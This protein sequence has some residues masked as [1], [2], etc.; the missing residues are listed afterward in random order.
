[1]TLLGGRTRRTLSA[2]ALMAATA[3]PFG[4]W[5]LSPAFAQ[6]T[7]YGPI[8][9]WDAA[10]KEI[11][12]AARYSPDGTHHALLIALRELHDPALKPF[13]QSLVQGEHWSIQIDGILGLAELDPNKQVDPFLLSQLK[14]ENDRS[15]AIAAAIGLDLVGPDQATAMLAWDDL[16]ARDRVVLAAELVHRGGKPA[17]DGITKLL[18]HRNDE[19]AGLAAFV[20]A[21][22]NNDPTPVET[23]RNRL[24]TLSAKDRIAVFAALANAIGRFKLT[25]ATSFLAETLKDPA[26]PI[27]ARTIGLAALLPLDP[28]AG[29]AAWKA[30]VES[31]SAQSSRVRLALLLLATDAK[32]PKGAALPLR[33]SSSELDPLLGR[34]AD[35]IDAM[36]S[37]GDASAAFRALVQTKHPTR[38][39]SSWPSLPSP[40]WRPPTPTR[41]PSGWSRPRRSTT[42]TT[43]WSTSC[44]SPCSG[45]TP[46]KRPKSPRPPAPRPRV[47]APP[48]S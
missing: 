13:F 33:K 31:D 4:G 30:A 5:V 15:T 19:V 10:V 41:S 47:A 6:A 23:Y 29:Y 45:R 17:L 35:A 40:S 8:S 38:R 34:L 43:T 46:R 25:G 37:G 28:D 12:A 21:T 14:G 16:P 42:S 20:V 26:L 27:E 48:S 2:F 44:S 3:A 32:L 24:A 39:R 7:G 18:D 22:V 9:P 11:R 1:M 36:A